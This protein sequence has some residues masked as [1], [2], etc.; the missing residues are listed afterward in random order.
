[1]IV[2]PPTGRRG[3]YKD[4]QSNEPILVSGPNLSG[5]IA[6]NILVH[7]AENVGHVFF[8]NPGVSRLIGAAVSTQSQS[9]RDGQASRKHQPIGSCRV[10]SLNGRPEIS[11]FS[12]RIGGANVLA[13]IAPNSR[14]RTRNFHLGVM[15]PS[16]FDG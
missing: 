15:K 16:H 3:D 12:K 10:S 14:R 2:K 8:S 6:T 1:V 9:L 4:G 13:K 7:F 5:L 11:R